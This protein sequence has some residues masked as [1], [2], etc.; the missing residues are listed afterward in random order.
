M[1]SFWARAR[2]SA[3]LVP[4]LSRSAAFEADCSQ[5]LSDIKSAVKKAKTA[6]AESDRDMEG[7]K[8]AMERCLKTHKADSDKIIDDL[9]VKQRE[10][11]TRELNLGGVIREI[12]LVAS[13]LEQTGGR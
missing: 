13:A 4:W 12:A 2:A 8:L 3:E 5:L 1:R 7:A 9:E 6:S 10:I 11:L